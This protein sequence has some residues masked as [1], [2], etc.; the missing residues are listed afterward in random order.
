[1]RIFAI[2][3]FLTQFHFQTLK[4][5]SNQQQYV[6]QLQLLQERFPQE[7]P[8]KLSRF[9]ERYNGDVHQVRFLKF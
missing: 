9:L 2:N 6:E 8:Q 7:S 3:I 5:A 4:M 1:M